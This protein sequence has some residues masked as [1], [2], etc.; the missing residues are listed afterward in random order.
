M[1]RGKKK[2]VKRKNYDRAIC[3]KVHFK[4]NCLERLKVRVNRHDIRE[5]TDKIY[6]KSYISEI[7]QSERIKFYHMYFKG[8]RCYICFDHNRKVPV[9]VLTEEMVAEKGGITFR[10][11]IN[12]RLRKLEVF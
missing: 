2:K 8:H 6:S 9:T 5:L 7:R 11:K 12:S 3:Q 1:A 4:R 10:G